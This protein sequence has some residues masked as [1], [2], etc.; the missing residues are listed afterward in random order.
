[1]AEASQ[2]WVA[3]LTIEECHIQLAVLTAVIRF[4]KVRSAYL[5]S[6]EAHGREGSADNPYSLFMQ[7]WK[8]IQKCL[9]S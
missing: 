8:Q 2:A 5:L 4:W 7:V 9:V 6:E 3:D 1:M